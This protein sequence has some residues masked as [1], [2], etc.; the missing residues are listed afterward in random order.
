MS[1]RRPLVHAYR[2]WHR[3]QRALAAARSAL[4]GQRAAQGVEVALENALM[5]KT[6]ELSGAD[7]RALFEAIDADTI[8]QGFPFAGIDGEE[9]EVAA[10]TT[11]DALRTAWAEPLSDELTQDL[12]YSLD[13]DAVRFGGF[14]LVRNRP[15]DRL[16]TVAIQ[17]HGPT[18]G[19]RHVLTSALRY[20]SV[21]ARTRHIGPPQ[22]VYDDFH[23][24]GVRNEG[25]ASPFN[26]RLI[27]R[28]ESGFCSAFPD[29]DRPLGARGSFFD[30]D[31]ADHPGAWSLDPPFIPEIMQRVD[32]IIR[33]WRERPD[34]VTV[35]LIVPMSHTPDAPIDET[36]VLKAGTHH[37][38]ALDGDLH[39]LPV[40]VGIHRIGELPGFDPERIRQGY[41]PRGRARSTESAETVVSA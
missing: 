4:A 27:D 33:S 12:G 22:C 18:D 8:A 38:E 3:S 6:M 20:A 10:R 25:F 5:G 32:A 35:L 24:W 31:P 26:S 7:T 37:Y 23:R 41:L 28:P 15:V 17:R 2:A 21:Y 39:P 16:I 19:L 13:G 1:T 30:I 36:V 40:D 14:R 11:I 9:A 29:V 34:P